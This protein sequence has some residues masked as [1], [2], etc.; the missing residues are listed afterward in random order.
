MT[1]MTTTLA[2]LIDRHGVEV[3]DH[4]DRG[5]LV[6]V[7]T[8]AQVQGDVGIWPAPH[9]PPTA[10]ELPAAGYPVVRGEAGGNTH[11]L[12]PGFDTTCY[13]TPTTDGGLR[14]G[15]LTVPDRGSAVLHHPEHGYLGIGPGTYELTR[16]REQADEIRMVAD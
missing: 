14:L 7:L 6:P 10:D 8:V 13:Y 15:V 11:L 9:L 12:L 5:A 16:Q 1:A 2:D 3:H 4:L